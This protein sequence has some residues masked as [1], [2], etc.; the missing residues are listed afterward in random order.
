VLKEAIDTPWRAS[1]ELRRL[2][3]V[4]YIRLMFNL[5]GVPWGQGWRI[6]GM[7]IIQRHRGSTIEFGDR[8]VLRSWVTSNPL[9]PNHAVVLATRTNQAVIKVGNDCG[10]TGATLVAAERIEIGNR[11][12]IGTNVTIVDT[13]FHPLSWQERQQDI[14]RGKYRPVIIEDD[15]FIGMNSLILKGVRVGRGSVIGAGSVVTKD[16]PEN[17]VVAGNPAQVVRDT[18]PTTLTG[19]TDEEHLAYRP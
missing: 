5:K 7:P 10:L 3:A 12:L 13:D 17:V 18:L 9:A 2:L 6:L 19:A 4:P 14:N 8:L 11:V 16:V 15:V 1:N